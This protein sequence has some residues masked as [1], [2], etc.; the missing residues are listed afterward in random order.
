MFADFADPLEKCLVH[1]RAAPAPTRSRFPPRT[2]LQGCPLK[3]SAPRGAGP[4]PAPP[5]GRRRRSARSGVTASG[6]LPE[7]SV[8]G[9]AS[10]VC[11]ALGGI[12]AAGLAHRDL[13]PSNVMVTIDGPKVVDLGIARA[14]DSVDGG[15]TS[16]GVA[17]GSP[18]FMSPEQIRGESLTVASDV[19]SLGAVLALPSSA[20]WA[21]AK[22]CAGATPAACPMPS[23]HC[24]G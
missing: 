6:P 20:P 11:R 7:Y 1:G 18:P 15:L 8:R 14:P 3:A 13:K 12:H 9:L 4:H 22:G 2:S 23:G 17:I 10:G 5:S 24:Q 19:Y 16:T 21:G